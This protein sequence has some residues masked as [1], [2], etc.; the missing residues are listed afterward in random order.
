LHT[1][2]AHDRHAVERALSRLELEPLA[3][4][5]YNS[6]SA[7]ERQRAVLAMALAQEPRVLLLDE[8]TVH[9]DLAHQLS[10]LQ[11]VRD[12]NRSQ[13]LAVLAA[14]HDLN[15]GSLPS[16]ALRLPR[17][18]VSAASMRGRTV[19]RPAPAPA[20][21]SHPRL[22][23]VLPHRATGPRPATCQRGAWWHTLSMVPPLSWRGPLDLHVRV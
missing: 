17:G 11:L 5:P 8:P 12:L 20:P 21:A 15:R 16:S 13:D 4:R 19:V 6:L 22:R 7:G 14:V 9:L 23:A 10:V 3:A 18:T 2:S 1:E